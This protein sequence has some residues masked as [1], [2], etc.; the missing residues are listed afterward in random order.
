MNIG[1]S[2]AIGQFVFVSLA[3]AALATAYLTSDFS[4]A[5][6]AQNSNSA[7]P[8]IYEFSGVWGNH[9]GSMLL[10]SLILSTFG[11]LVAIFGRSLPIRLKADALAVQ[12]LIGVAFLAFILFTS[13]PFAAW[14]R[15]RWR[16]RIL[17]PILQDPGPRDPPAAA[18]SGLCW[19]LY[20]L[21]LRRRSF[22]RRTHRRRLGPLC[23]GLSLIAWGFLTLGIAMGFILGLLH[24]RLGRLLVLGPRRK[25]S[26]MPWLAGTALC[27]RSP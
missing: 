22:D 21:F 14:I 15:R 8:T 18:L 13:N 10:W 4:V 26:F 3:F 11:A 16:A 20:R 25:P 27:I 6:V 12:G 23:Q 9:E 19:L 2:A 17:N 7:L 1:V 5:N 24:P